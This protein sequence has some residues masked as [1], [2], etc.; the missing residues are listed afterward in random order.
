MNISLSPE[1]QLGRM[2][3]NFSGTAYEIADYNYDNLVKYGI[4]KG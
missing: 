1:E 2:L 4:V 3:H